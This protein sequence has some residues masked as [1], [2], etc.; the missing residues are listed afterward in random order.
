ME[1]E[2]LLSSSMEKKDFQLFYVPTMGKKTNSALFWERR[3]SQLFHGEADLLSSS[4]GKKTFSTLLCRR[5]PSQ[6]LYGVEGPLTYS[7]L[8]SGAGVC[9]LVQQ[10]FS[11]LLWK[12]RPSQLLYWEEDLHLVYYQKAYSS[13][14]N[15]YGDH[16]WPQMSFNSSL[17]KNLRIFSLCRTTKGILS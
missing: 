11:I 14:E 9:S 6:V 15:L 2:D 12:I 8:F 5:R 10:T 7:Q 13:V 4:K 3:P 17:H 16:L 1:K